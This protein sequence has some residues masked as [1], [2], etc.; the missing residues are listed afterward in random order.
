MCDKLPTK[1]FQILKLFSKHRDLI[2]VFY[3]VKCD[4]CLKTV[5]I[6]S[7]STKQET[8]CDK[9][10]VKTET[11][12]FV[13]LPIQKQLSQ[14]IDNNWSYIKTFDTHSATDTY[15]D[16]HDGEILK[17]ILKYYQDE[18]IN[19]LSLCLNVDGAKKFKSN[20]CSLWPIQFTL[21][22]LPPQ[23]RFQ[24]QNIILGSLFY[25]DTD[26]KLDF[27]DY[28]LPLICELNELRKNSFTKTIDNDDFT[29]KPIITHLCVD[30][31]A[32][33]K[34]LQTKQFGGYDACSY[35]DISGKLV[36]VHK[37]DDEKRKK[38]RNQ[39]QKEFTQQVRY[40]EANGDYQL[41]DET[42]TLKKMLAASSSSSDI[43]GIKGK[44][45][46]PV[47]ESGVI[48]VVIIRLFF[49]HILFSF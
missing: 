40:V 26:T 25:T 41:R 18:D 15:S 7:D 11:N 22:F 35:C 30:L 33:C 16:A 46:V 3:F 38:K 2:E 27:R 6:K 45:Y 39:N 14:T 23:I 8:C 42:E 32:K 19:I 31:P 17:N 1:K 44:N 49:R 9:I 37:V 4:K 29:F 36:Q 47:S 5:K 10:L 20:N 13:Y 48:R 28:M 43:D 12:F 21:N 24:T 34:I